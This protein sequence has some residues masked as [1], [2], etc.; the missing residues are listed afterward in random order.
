MAYTGNTQILNYLIKH[1][2]L[3]VKIT[4]E[5]DENCFFLATRKGHIKVLKILVNYANTIKDYSFIFKNNEYNRFNAFHNALYN[6]HIKILDYLIKIGFNIYYIDKLNKWSYF[7]Y[8]IQ[9]KK[10]KSLDFLSKKANMISYKKTNMISYKKKFEQFEYCLTN[11]EK[12]FINHIY[13]NQL[14]FI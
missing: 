8:C 2:L 4:T 3:D 10:F 11:K 9:W 14:L 6:K 5:N 13:C 7:E 1:N 12:F